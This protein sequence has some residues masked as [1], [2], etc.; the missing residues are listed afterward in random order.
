MNARIFTQ[1]SD[2]FEA[3]LEALDDGKTIARNPWRHGTRNDV[4]FDFDGK[5]WLATIH[6][7]H[8]EGWQIYGEIRAVETHEVERTVKVWEPIP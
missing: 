7:H 4:V 1:C 5:H 6:M 3:V 2:E 8:D